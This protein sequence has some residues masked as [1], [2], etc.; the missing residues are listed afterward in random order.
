MRFTM[1]RITPFLLYR[2][3]SR[4]D[5][6]C[7]GKHK[8]AE[9]AQEAL[10]SLAGVM[11]LDRHT[12]LDDAPAEDNNADGLDRGEDEVGKVVD[13]IDIPTWTM[14]QPRII[15]PMALI[16]EKIKSDRLLTTVIG[17]PPVA[18][19]VVLKQTTQSVRTL[20]TDMKILVRLVVGF[21]I[22]FPPL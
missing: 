20:H 7:K 9:Q 12:N 1:K 3:D 10:G 22:R 17:S 5:L 11:A 4:E 8:P 6:L 18:K 21:F 13:W 16:A 2:A 19:A 14:P 15:I